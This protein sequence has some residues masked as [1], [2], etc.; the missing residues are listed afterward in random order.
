MSDEGFT[1][2]AVHVAGDRSGSV[3]QTPASVPIYQ[4]STWRFGS[5]DEFAEVL[6]GARAGYAYGRGYGNPTVEAFESVLASLEGTEACFAFSSGM[7]AIH[8]VCVA[9]AKAG[10]RI[11]TSRELYGGT[12]SLFSSLL[13]RYGISVDEVDPHDLQ[14]VRRALPGAALFY[15]E[16]I[17]NPLCT[18]AD[19][20]ALGSACR[21]AGVPA[22]VDN[23]FA[24]PYLCNPVAHGF[25]FVIHSVTKMIA[26]HSDV[27]AGAVCCSAADR[28]IVKEAALHTG[29]AMPP[30]EA[31]LC[32]RGIET[33]ELRMERMC[34]NAEALTGMLAGRPEVTT[35]H[36]P[37]LQSHGHHAYAAK[38]FRAHLFGTMFSFEIA[39]G[40]EMAARWCEAL[41]VA[42]I[43]AS[44]GGTHTLVCHPAS[45]THRQ[46]PP[47]VRRAG[48]LSDGLI[49][50]SPGI[51]NGEDLVADFAGAFSKL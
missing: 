1:T 29:G 24:S 33:L 26:G 3:P 50:V 45:T 20:P 40:A 46:V 51:E 42:W 10:D 48:G 25:G 32:L 14:A 9:L 18:V 30:F 22:V 2:R 47:E 12:Y 43:G 11:V 21:E 23:T 17:A 38:A 28:E 36:Y 31:W 8:A 7:S 4:T 34:S 37:G 16:T 44:L 41:E 27:L 35:V 39:G 19:L 13:P 15:C 6:S 49:R 5:G